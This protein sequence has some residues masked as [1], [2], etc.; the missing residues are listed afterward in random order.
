MT[1]EV[2]GGRTGP[3]KTPRRTKPRPAV[4]QQPISIGEVDANIFSCPVCAR[5]L[6]TGAQRC[7][8]CG[9]RL[10]L[11]TPARRVGIF[12]SAGL[13]IG[14][15]FGWSF[16]AAVGAISAPRTAGPTASVSPAG[17][18]PIIVG[19]TPTPTIPAISRSAVGQAAALDGRLMDAGTS[20][21]TALREKAL[22][23]AAVADTLRS[24]AADAAFGE[25]L[26]S[27]MGA[28]DEAY[29]LSLDLGNLYGSVR[30]TA[31]EGLAASITNAPAYRAAAQKM[32]AVLAA[33][34]RLDTRLRDLAATT[35][36]KL[37]GVGASDP[38]P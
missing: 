19:Q 26:A 32:L 30:S 38:P 27:R 24:L 3:R 36:I 31:R 6:A 35:D 22:D 4:S 29:A 37:P 34:P 11:A 1:A 21:R 15:L 17:S 7:P 10:I 13:V 18:V 2:V 23:S 14:L 28:W 12:V 5:P 25:D 8:G 16:S 33:L 20:L 9:T